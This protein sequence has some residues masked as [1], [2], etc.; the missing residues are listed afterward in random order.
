MLLKE[1]NAVKI[2]SELDETGAEAGESGATRK[3]E[4]R[5]R[6]GRVEASGTNT[7]SGTRDEAGTRGV[8]SCR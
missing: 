2:G 4:A 1:R 8:E 3:H 5:T 6:R 7:G